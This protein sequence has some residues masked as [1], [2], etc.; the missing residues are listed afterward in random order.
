MLQKDTYPLSNTRHSTPGA[1]AVTVACRVSF[2]RRAN[3]PKYFPSLNF[4]MSIS[5]SDP[6]IF[7]KVY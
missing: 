1:S 4:P 7:S 5:L 3:S 2:L 6:E